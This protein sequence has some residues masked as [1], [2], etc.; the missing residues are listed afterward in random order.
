MDVISLT[1]Y[2]T[3]DD[4]IIKGDKIDV[5]L[6][7]NL[8]EYLSLLLND[9][10]F[11]SFDKKI[12]KM[13]Y[14]KLGNSYYIINV[15]PKGL[16]IEGNM[17]Y[18]V[19][20]IDNSICNINPYYLIGS[21]IFI[22]EEINTFL[23]DDIINYYFKDEYVIPFNTLLQLILDYKDSDKVI[24]FTDK[25]DNIPFWFHMIASIIPLYD[26][27]DL[28]MSYGG[29]I[30]ELRN[31]SKIIYQGSFD[32]K[33]DSNTLYIDFVNNIMPDVFI[34]NYVKTL[35]DKIRISLA[36][37]MEFRELVSNLSYNYHLPLDRALNLYYFKNLELS[38]I[39]SSK[40]MS[41]A[42]IDSKCDVDNI[43]IAKMLYV[44]MKKYNI[45]L[46][47][48]E[49]F[50][51]VY[52]YNPISHDYIIEAYFHNLSKFQIDITGEV[53][54]T[55]TKIKETIP[56][57]II[58]YNFY[59][60]R[61]NMFS[62]KVLDY[63]F[64]MSLGYLLSA[65][66]LE[67]NKYNN[68]SLVPNSDLEY[69]LT[70]LI[71]ECDK[72]NLKKFLDLIDSYNSYAKKRII[73]K[74][75]NDMVSKEHRTFDKIGIDFSFDILEEMDPKDSIE[76]L[77]KALRMVISQNELFKCYAIHEEKNKK[78]YTELRK[79]IENDKRF[80]G[81]L[82]NTDSKK[83]SME[84]NVSLTFL[85]E[86]YNIYYSNPLNDDDYVFKDKLF[87]YIDNI[88]DDSNKVKALI[89]CYQRYFKDKN[90]SFKSNKDCIRRISQEIY[91]YPYELFINDSLYYKELVSIANDLKKDE[92]NA[93]VIFNLVTLGLKLKRTIDDKTYREDFFKVYLDKKFI[94]DDRYKDY[95]S[96]AYIKYLFDS[97]NLY[98][99][100][101]TNFNDIVIIYHNIYNSIIKNAVV[102]DYMISYLSNKDNIKS[103]FIFS[104]VSLYSNN[105]YR[106]IFNSSISEYK[107]KNL[108]EFINAI[109]YYDIK[110]EYKN[111]YYSY[112]IELLIKRSNKIVGL[113]YKIKYRKLLG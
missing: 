34:S 96:E 8:K 68:I 86:V 65:T 52:K 3:K 41:Y 26:I 24:V 60:K 43:T 83:Y 46:D 106:A 77:F 42:I 9:K 90:I 108:K 66:I 110:E 64:P 87:Q 88:K 20:I 1:S 5:S 30:D 69:I 93:I 85:D 22:N 49:I 72:V 18:Y 33:R 81:F 54:T 32:V 19:N 100:D 82:S 105:N 104:Y 45:D 37:A 70:D 15:L 50:R 27:K 21:D 71:I 48:L 92:E 53:L 59:L 38:K 16:S 31:Y 63:K 2:K 74:V 55:Y 67:D 102:K 7:D 99:I 29:E 113:F 91:K 35:T 17:E 95:F 6:R 76:V 40:D 80:N 28:T 98:I 47:I 111:R 101:D 97:F 11:L 109:S 58:E 103:L 36:E 39:S 112:I 61:H 56:F 25:L 107:N 78:Y 14:V 73:Y 57:D 84:E 75:L 44:T 89:S 13:S 51:Y 62:N 10:D 23:N 79:I 4:I 12:F 94:I